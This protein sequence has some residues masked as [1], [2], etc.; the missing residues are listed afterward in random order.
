MR[1]EPKFPVIGDGVFV[2]A[3]AR[4]LGGIT[5]GNGAQI[6]ANAVVLKDVPDGAT[7]VGVPAIIKRR[8]SAATDPQGAIAGEAEGP[9]RIDGVEGER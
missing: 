5:I 7:A 3:G 6:G 4:I 8:S 9:Q 1:S 2:G